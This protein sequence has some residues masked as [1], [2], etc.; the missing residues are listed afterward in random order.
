M[1]LPNVKISLNEIGLGTVSVDGVQ[2]HG[3][4]S[5]KVSTAVGGA[6]KVELH[7]YAKVLYDGIADVS[8]INSIYRE[9]EKET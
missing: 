7:M 9:F 5:V 4:H 3:I 1:K 8:T 6:T 2:I